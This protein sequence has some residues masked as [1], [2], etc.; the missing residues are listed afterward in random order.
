M[1]S[2][3]V[4]SA[5]MR[6]AEQAAFDRGVAVEALMD[7]AGAG[8][9]AAVEQFFPAPGTCVVFAGKGHNGG[10]ALV[11]ARCLQR[12][13]WNVESHLAYPENE[14]SELTRKKLAELASEQ[15]PVAS[16]IRPGHF[17]ILDGLLGVGAKRHLRD[18]IRSAA[19]E[20]NRRRR[21]HN[22]F[23]FAIDLPTGL[24]SDTGELDPP[25][26]VKADV[27][28]T[29]GFAKR[30][31]V[32][33]SAIDFVGRLE[34]VPLPD[35]T[36]PT[37]DH[38]IIAARHSLGQVLPRRQFSAYKNLF[39]RI[40]VVAGSEG[41]LGAAILATKGALRAG[42]GLVN[43]FVPRALYSTVAALAPDEAMVKPVE[44]YTELLNEN[45]V[46]VWA[47]GP[48]LGTNRAEEL[49]QVIEQAD[50]PMVVDADGLNMMATKID[51]LNRCRGPRLVTPH[52]GEMKRLFDA[53]KMPR[54]KI[55]KQF[56]EKFPVTLLFKGS[57]TIVCQ[58]D[59]PLSYNSTGNPGMAAG[60]T[61]DVLTGVCAALL[62][63]KLAP[64]E[65]ARL[66]AW[67]C[68]R[69]AEI[70]VFQSGQSEESLLPR[71]VIDHLGSAFNDLRRSSV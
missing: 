37:R 55:A 3:I 67:L 34:V 1:D 69:A 54:A 19:Q 61:G 40:G 22:A 53:G 35:L 7:Q 25:E 6:A 31:L 58:R 51:I 50:Q 56:C 17:V 27:T 11:A 14:C 66:G 41:F 43:M 28:V 13:G 45:N 36:V 48:G 8:V 9:A 71:D 60:G 24:D 12:L 38:E 65:A 10:D 2:P 49:L 4:S 42:A 18:P 47:I 15:F 46:D 70:A 23:V 44:S 64:Y 16:D 52:P 30:G 26:C 32:A 29:I 59:R 21:E 68:G 33:D 63:Q 20:I 62:G 57:R 5:E 39:G